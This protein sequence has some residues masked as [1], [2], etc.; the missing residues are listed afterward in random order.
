MH[1]NAGKGRTGTLISCFLIYSGLA[2]NANDAI[3]YYGF[4]RFS[5]G[6]GVTQPSQLR[7]VDYFEQVYKKVIASPSLKIP[8]LLVIENPPNKWG[9]ITNLKPFVEIL[10]ATNFKKVKL[11]KFNFIRFGVVMLSEKIVFI[12][13]TLLMGSIQ[14][15]TL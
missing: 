7:Y 13:R 10:N 15:E 4:K 11:T 6:K 2:D 3:T 5:H 1:C 9:A 8:E 12:K 14:R